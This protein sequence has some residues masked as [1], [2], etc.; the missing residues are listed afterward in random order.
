M[1]PIVRIEQSLYNDM[2]MIANALIKG[3]SMKLSGK[4]IS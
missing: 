2:N 4:T 3:Y 1:E